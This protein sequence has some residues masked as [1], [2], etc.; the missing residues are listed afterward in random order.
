MEKNKI[1]FN[2]IKIGENGRKT[3][4]FID[5]PFDVAQDRFSI[6]DTWGIN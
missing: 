4:F 2:P 6:V 5:Y 1:F 3:A